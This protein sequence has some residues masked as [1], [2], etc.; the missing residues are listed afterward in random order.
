MPPNRRPTDDDARQSMVLVL[1]GL[2]HDTDVFDLVGELRALHP[3]NNTFPGEVFMALAIDALD[4]GSF[5]R[6]EPLEY[7]DLSKRLLPEVALRGRNDHRKSFYTLVTPPAWRGGLNPDLLGE[8]SW[9]NSDDYWEFALYAL[10]IYVRAA[11]ERSELPVAT[12]CQ[13]IADRHGIE[14]TEHP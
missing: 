12:V 9:W 2:A 1:T 3:K 13:S 6:D 10:V 8:V 14:L 11:A 7:E 5:S 4:V